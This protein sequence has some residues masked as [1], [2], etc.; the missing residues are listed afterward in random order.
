MI[1]CSYP[2]PVFVHSYMRWRLGQ[3]EKVSAH[4]R[5]NPSR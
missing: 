5:S 4:C 2:M 3:W 1:A